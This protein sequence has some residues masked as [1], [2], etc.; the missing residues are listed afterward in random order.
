VQPTIP[1]QL[2]VV[3][4]KVIVKIN[5]VHNFNFTAIPALFVNDNDAVVNFGTVKVKF[6][7]SAGEKVVAFLVGLSRAHISLAHVPDYDVTRLEIVEKIGASMPMR[8]GKVVFVKRGKKTEKT[9][10]KE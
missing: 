5:E 4:G 9:T 2:C 1:R 10:P 8:D 6:S 3:G 7:Q